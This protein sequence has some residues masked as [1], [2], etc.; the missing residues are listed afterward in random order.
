M[1]ESVLVNVD[2]LMCHM[3][4][5]EFTFIYEVVGALSLCA[6]CTQQFKINFVKTENIV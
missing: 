1:I 3:L 6:L 5:H 4:Y 2:S